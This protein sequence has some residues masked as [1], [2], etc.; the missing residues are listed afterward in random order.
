MNPKIRQT[1]FGFIQIEDEKYDHD[2][3]ISLNGSINKRKKKLSKEV[4]G[5]SHVISLAEAEFIYEDGADILILG[6][7]MMDRVKLSDEAGQFFENHHVKTYLESTPMAA[8][9]WN[10]I[11]G[12]VIGLFHITC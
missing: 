1:V 8:D 12:N 7:G 4:F 5:T 3:F 9:R 11:S 2:V 10:E 6:C